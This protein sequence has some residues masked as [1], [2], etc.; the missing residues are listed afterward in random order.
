MKYIAYS[1]NT[2]EVFISTRRSALNLA[3]QGLTANFGK[4]DVIAE[5]EGS[6]L[7]GSKLK[8]PLTSYEVVYALPMLTIKDDKGTGIVTSVPSDSPDDFAALMD[9]KNKEALRVKYN[10]PDESV[11]P[12]E[13]VFYSS[14]LLCAVLFLQNCVYRFPLLRF[15]SMETWRRF[16]RAKSSR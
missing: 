16:E 8:A 4:F 9:L 11:F 10:L 13:P 5:I 12:F 7:I 3:Y 6:E 2:E 14:L 15:P 1:V